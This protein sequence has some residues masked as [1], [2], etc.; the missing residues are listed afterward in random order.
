MIVWLLNL[1]NNGRHQA[2]KMQLMYGITTLPT[3]I[4]PDRL[5]MLIA[6]S[7]MVSEK[8]GAF[9]EFGVFQ[10][11]SLDLLSR[12]HPDRLIYGIDSF[13]GLPQGGAMDTYHTTKGEFALS[14]EEFRNVKDY[15]T[16]AKFWG[17]S[18]VLIFKGFSP[19]IFNNMP[20]A[21]TF[22]FVHVDVDLYQSVKDALDYF[23]PRLINTGIMI[24]DDYGFPTTPGAK[25]AIDE[26]NGRCSYRGE[27]IFNNGHKSGQYIIIK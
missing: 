12:L 3:G 7:W 17:E 16:S 25:Q 6:Y 5:A 26:F 15:F 14:E 13:E 19:E 24:F 11:G 2:I 27:V 10:G 20:S 1:A 22:S 8:P 4:S 18:N 23:Y 21:Q 9:A